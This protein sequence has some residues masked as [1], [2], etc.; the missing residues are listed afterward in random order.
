IEKRIVMPARQ[1]TVF[2]TYR[3]LEGEPITLE[4]RPGLHFRSHDA[5]VSLPLHDAYSISTVD[6]HYVINATDE[7]PP[8]RL[9]LAGR[10]PRFVA[11]AERIPELL[12]RVEAHRRYHAHRGLWNAGA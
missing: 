3:L 1:N 6:G 5:A 10:N 4:L 11:N 12:Y 9:R 2:V 7:R 8:L